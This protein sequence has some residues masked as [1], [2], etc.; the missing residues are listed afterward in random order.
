VRCD[1]VPEWQS[2]LDAAVTPNRTV[3][4]QMHVWINRE[5][6]R[7]LL[8]AMSYYSPPTDCAPRPSN[9][10]QQV[11]VVEYFSVD[12]DEV[13]EKLKLRCPA[14]PLSIAREPP[15]IQKSCGK[16]VG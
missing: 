7:E 11:I 8:L 12:V 13:V 5:A 9:D 15:A 14:K 3:H 6:R 10:D 2:F 4:Q 16:G 1:W